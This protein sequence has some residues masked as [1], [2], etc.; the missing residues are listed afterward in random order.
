V[1][2]VPAYSTNLNKRLTKA[3]KYYFYD[4]G[5]AARLQ[6]WQAAE[7]LLNSPLFGHL[8]ENLVVGE[9][10]RF[11]LNRGSRPNLYFVRSKEKVEADLIVDLGNQRY[12]AV[13]VK[14]T[15]ERWSQKQIELVDSLG[16][17]IVDR[18]VVG[19]HAGMPFENSTVVAVS[20]VWDRLNGIM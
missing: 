19:I 12:L 5:L 3:P 10:A 7:P 18:W 11:F 15:P 6:G 20:E 14:V 8:F 17:S 2:P 13:E 1:L 16:L 4:V 9:I